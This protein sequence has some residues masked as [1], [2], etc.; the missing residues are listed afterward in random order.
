[1]FYSNIMKQLIFH[2]RTSNNCYFATQNVQ[3]TQA[4][5][6]IIKIMKTHELSNKFQIK[7]QTKTKNSLPATS[8]RTYRKKNF[9]NTM[10]Q[11]L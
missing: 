8:K 11:H 5:A 1:M 6:F 7:F 4:I 9:Q 3:G 10:Y 2:E